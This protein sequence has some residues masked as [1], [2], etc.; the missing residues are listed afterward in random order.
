MDGCVIGVC[1]C[2]YVW[3]GVLEVC[4]CMCVSERVC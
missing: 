2:M 3:M 4:V 1:V